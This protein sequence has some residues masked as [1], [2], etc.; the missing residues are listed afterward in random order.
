MVMIID[1]CRPSFVDEFGYLHEPKEIID[2]ILT[3][4]N[5]D[6]LPIIVNSDQLKFGTVNV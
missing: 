6:N 4:S 5:P 1:A 3:Y 2:L